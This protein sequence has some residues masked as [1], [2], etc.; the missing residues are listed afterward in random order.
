MD[1]SYFKFIPPS[2][3]PQPQPQ[4]QQQQQKPRMLGMASHST[5]TTT[6]ALSSTATLNSVH[7]V[8][9][10]HDDRLHSLNKTPDS[11]AT[12][13]LQQANQT[14]SIVA[15]RSSNFC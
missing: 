12:N 3:M 13:A 9:D 1:Q 4:Q 7:V 10:Q 11:I 15:K 5:A 2:F 8:A 6:A 14:K